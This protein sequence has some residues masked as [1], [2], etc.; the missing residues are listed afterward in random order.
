VN[1]AA[2][3]ASHAAPGEVLVTDTVVDAVSDRALDLT[4]AGVVELKGLPR[5]IRLYRAGG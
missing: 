4:D 5:P 3:I 1:T 2:R